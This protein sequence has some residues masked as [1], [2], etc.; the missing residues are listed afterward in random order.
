MNSTPAVL[1][2][3]VFKANAA[4]TSVRWGT[5]REVEQ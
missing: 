1:G 4:L 5:S 3:G 2:P